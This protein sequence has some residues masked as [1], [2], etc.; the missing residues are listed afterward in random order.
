[1]FRI[2]SVI[3]VLF[4][5]GALAFGMM[6]MLNPAPSG[7][8]SIEAPSK[9]DV[10][11][12]S[13]P[14]AIPADVPKTRSLEAA[15]TAPPAKTAP[16]QMAK[17]S[18]GKFTQPSLDS[19]EF[20]IESTQS[21]PAGFGAL[22]TVPIAHE[23]PTEAMFGR[24]F[25]VTVAIDATGDET[26]ADALPGRGAIVEGTAQISTVVEARLSGQAFDFEATTPLK[27]AVSPLTENVW[28][29]RVTPTQA[30]SHDLIVELYALDERGVALPLRTFQDR[31]D[32]QVSRV[33][34]AIAF[35]S[36]IS[37][38]T[39]IIGGIGSFLAGLLGLIRLFWKS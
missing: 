34:Q 15:E 6:T 35:A 38:V 4:G 9:S 33:G 2:F 31:I 17:P 21:S 18:N 24:P 1:M 23:T 11:A 28:R 3:L 39:M 29:W 22:K 20:G 25:D 12:V 10:P 14:P 30:G 19:G 26:A 7:D 36:D 16:G 8:L 13:E 27:Q 37:P 32:V 5:L